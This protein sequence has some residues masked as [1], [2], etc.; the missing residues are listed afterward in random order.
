MA[1][2]KVNYLDLIRA[3]PMDL[4]TQARCLK[5]LSWLAVHVAEKIDFINEAMGDGGRTDYPAEVKNAIEIVSK[6]IK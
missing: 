5:S 6:Y 1:K 4:V 3:E 2:E